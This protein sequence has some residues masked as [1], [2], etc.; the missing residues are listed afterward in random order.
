MASIKGERDVRK[1]FEVYRQ[2]TRRMVALVRHPQGSTI[3]DKELGEI[4]GIPTGEVTV[5]R[6]LLMAIGVISWSGGAG[7]PGVWWVMKS[8]AE[9]EQALDLEMERQM[10]GGQS[11]ESQLHDRRRIR[12]NPPTRVS[13]EKVAVETDRLGLPVGAV[14]GPD[15]PKPMHDLG[16][17]E[18]SHRE[19]EALVLSAKQYVAAKA[20]GDE[21]VARAQKLMAELEEIGVPVPEELRQAATVPKDDRLE[22]IALVLP[23]VEALERRVV[24][25]SDQ[26]RDQPKITDLQQTVSKQRSQ[27]ERLVAERTQAALGERGRR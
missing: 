10:R 12:R 5:T 7:Q 27:I 9:I 24:A 15:A 3:S 2:R 18:R 23:Y 21:K 4:M 6:H 13:A 26:L 25:L 17:I 11:P 14:A 1:R 19:P 22:V 8:D 16:L 20:G